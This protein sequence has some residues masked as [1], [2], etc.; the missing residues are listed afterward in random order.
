MTMAA[1]TKP[2]KHFKKTRFTM[3]S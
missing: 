2:L 3:H 1:Y